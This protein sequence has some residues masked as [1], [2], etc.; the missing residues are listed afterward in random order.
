MSPSTRSPP[1]RRTAFTTNRARSTLSAFFPCFWASLGLFD[2]LRLGV[3]TGVTEPDVRLRGL[4][5]SLEAAVDLFQQFLGRL[6]GDGSFLFA[7]EVEE[8]RLFFEELGVLVHDPLEQTLLGGIGR[9]GKSQGVRHEGE[10]RSHPL[11][12]GDQAEQDAVFEGS[13]Q[14][15]VANHRVEPLA[16]AVDSAV[17]LLE[18]VRVEGQFQV[19]QVVASLMEVQALRGGIR[20]DQDQVVPAP[21]LLGDGGSCL[22]TI[23]AA[24][25]HDLSDLRGVMQG[26]G[27]GLLAIDVLGVDQDVRPGSALRISAITSLT[28]SIL[29]SLSQAGF[30]QADHFVELLDDVGDL[31]ELARAAPRLAL[32]R[33]ELLGKVFG[34]EE[35]PFLLL[36][37]A[38]D[39][40]AVEL[41]LII[42]E[43]LDPLP[44][45]LLV[46]GRLGEDVLK[47]LG[48]DL[49]R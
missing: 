10:P 35:V 16:V 46:L 48:N 15:Q 40:E 24:H 28:R 26:F 32:E 30:G 39:A 49:E 18:A 11:I 19:D 34:F 37:D 1:S 44:A 27:E 2:E 13:P 41:P 21:E 20:A 5:E 33:R 17:T 6:V 3:Q 43:R 31:A 29:G 22:F 23:E 45:T 36:L 7:L 8:R 9:R 47:P 38:Q 42:A 14:E 4:L 12:L 25:G